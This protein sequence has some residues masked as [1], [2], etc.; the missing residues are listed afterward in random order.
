MLKHALT[1]KR[2]LSSGK[3]ILV[4]TLAENRQGTFFQ[5]HSNYLSQHDKSLSP[6][7]LAHSDKLQQAPAHIHYGLHGVF[8]DSLPDGWGLYVMDRVLRQHGYVPQQVTALERLAFMGDNCLGALSYTP[9][10]PITDG[11]NTFSNDMTNE[12]ALV[13]LGQ[14]AVCEFEGSLSNDGAFLKQLLNASGSGGARPKLNVTKTASGQYSTHP[15]AVGE[16]LI[17]KLTSA[18]FALA[19]VESV[20]EYLYLQ[21]AQAVGIEVPVFELMEV[22]P[23]QFWLQLQRFDCPRMPFDSAITSQHQKTSTGRYHM[24]SACGLLDAP[25]R[26]PSLDYVDLIKATRLLCGVVQAQQLTK[27]ALFN[28]LLVNQDDHSKNFAF[29]ADDNDNW[30]LS[31][32]YDI[33]YSPSAYGEHMT[34]FAGNGK[35]PNKNAITQM[36]LQAGFSNSKPLYAML[37]EIYEVA[38]SFAKRAKVYGVPDELVNEIEKAINMRWQLLNIK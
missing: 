35:Y 22:Q 21:M 37:D 18:K 27:R 12:L 20:V 10:L 8:A 38:Q 11:T 13:A 7:R 15:D 3:Q 17:I 28:F 24:M 29:L 36:A 16:K 19:H 26:Q 1:V 33:V 23:G 6:F 30:Q 2:T 32:C 9:T 5:Y 25:F 34:A 31:P 14:S 4:G